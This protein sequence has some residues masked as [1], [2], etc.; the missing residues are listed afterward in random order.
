[1]SFTDLLR[2]ARTSRVSV[3]H[4]FLTNYDPNSDRIF[5]FVEGYPDQAFYGAQVQKYVPDSK[6]VFIYNCEGKHNVYDTYSHVVTRYPHCERTLFFVDKDVD[7]I[8]G[9]QWPSDPRIFV[10]ECYSIEN[11]IVCRDS[12]SRYLR[13]YVKLRRVDVDMNVVLSQFEARLN[14]FHILILPI[15]AWIVIQRRAGNRVRL[16]DFRPGELFRVSDV[17][18][19]RQ[20]KRCAIKYLTRV[21]GTSASGPVFRRMR[22][23]NAELRRLPAKVYVRGKFEVW[24]FV[25]FAHRIIEGL[26]KV[27]G[28]V[29]GSVSVQAPLNESTSIQ[30][31]APGVPTPTSLDAFLKFHLNRASRKPTAVVGVGETSVLRRILSFFKLS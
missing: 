27:A 14:E 12:L 5:V 30:L 15:M 18:I 25:E 29:G 20:P 16:S 22:A 21:T 13:D 1:M 10:T 31:L 2:G 28:E 26:M 8:I 6:R 9:Q 11:Y 17:G 24:W 3:L 4:K 23:T 7:D 19:S